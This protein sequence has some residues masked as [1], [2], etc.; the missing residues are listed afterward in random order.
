MFRFYSGESDKKQTL[1]VG[2]FIELQG[3]IV[4]IPEVLILYS[5]FYYSFLL[6][7]PLSLF[8]AIIVIR[9][10]PRRLREISWVEKEQEQSK[11]WS[12][13]AERE[14]ETRRSKTKTKFLTVANFNK[15]LGLTLIAEISVLIIGGV[16]AVIINSYSLR[17]YYGQSVSWFILITGLLFLMTRPVKTE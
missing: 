15:I 17:E 12:R 5:P 10:L 13:E 4:T 14:L 3:L 9:Y 7:V 11:W 1:L 2:L 8:T 6:P 16:Y